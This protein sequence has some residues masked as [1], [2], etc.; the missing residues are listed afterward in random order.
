MSRFYRSKAL[1]A[2]CIEDEQQ[3]SVNRLARELERETHLES[4]ISPFNN[5]P[6]LAINT[7][8]EHL[9]FNHVSIDVFVTS[10]AMTGTTQSIIT[11]ISNIVEN[12]NPCL[13][14][15]TSSEASCNSNIGPVSSNDIFYQLNDQTGCFEYIASE[16]ENISIN[17]IEDEKFM[18]E[19]KKRKKNQENR[20]LGQSYMGH[21]VV[22]IDNNTILKE[23]I[24]TER[25]MKQQ[26]C[27]HGGLKR[28]ERS[29]MCAALSDEMRE[30][31]FRYFWQLPTWD[32]KK[33]YIN[34]LI[35]TRNILR[36]RKSS[37]DINK[38]CS[39][40]DC[41]LPV[42]NGEK[43]RVCKELF[44]A[45]FDL[46]KDMFQLWIRPN[47]HVAEISNKNKEN[48]IN[49]LTSKTTTLKSD[50]V[51]KWL[52]CVPKVPSHY[53]RANSSRI[54]VE[55][56]FES[57]T[58][59]HSVYTSW[60]QANNNLYAVKR[61]K[62]QEILKEYKISIY[63]PR[64][65]Q[66]DICV[67]YKQGNI[68]DELY[69]HHIVKK[70]E[71]RVAKQEAISQMSDSVIVVSMDMQSVLLC[72]K[73]LVSEQYYKM[74]LSLHNFSFYVKNTK[75]VYLYVWHEGDGGVTANNITSCIIDFLEKYCSAYKKVIL[76]SDG[77]AYQNKNKTLCNAL[78]NLSTIKGIMIEQ[79]ILEKGHTMMEVDSVHST[80]EKKFKSPIYTPTDYIS[81]MLQARPSQPYI[82][83]YLEYTFFKNYEDCPGGFSSIRPGRKT[84][85][86]TVTDIRG[87]LYFSG[88]VKY[89]LRHIDDW[90]NLPQ[91]RASATYT[92]DPIQLYENP[93]KIDST[94][95][96][97]LQSLKQYMHRDYHHFYDNLNH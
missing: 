86:A 48:N 2:L 89:K 97:H 67:S 47:I 46:K 23:I 70:D 65:D 27:N 74:K 55:E 51:H 38:K 54:Y 63:K 76:I 31:I 75:D 59:M 83:H 40:Y 58:H 77:C 9:N 64:K 11:T 45:T 82:V 50:S 25:K 80:L 19:T 53:C 57:F 61:K 7:I 78:S 91:R 43:V 12:V 33:A 20:L 10:T 52:E 22:K 62:F 42:A 60:C 72:P 94:K 21:K 15:H 69:Q 66:C 8:S 36:R 87:L 3:R 24:K 28:S 41:Y 92:R 30:D 81:R 44:L 6:Q 32:A 68:S 79:I 88:E 29:Y 49:T 18:S 34:G 26:P 39:G 71:A 93:I 90:A 35:Q 73:L 17:I 4:G 96:T 85:D 1:V 16:K 5:E 13:I 56:S 37:V 14:T 95:F 84:G